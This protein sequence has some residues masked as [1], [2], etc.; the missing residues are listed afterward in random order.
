MGSIDRRLPIYLWLQAAQYQIILLLRF[1]PL[2]YS[3]QEQSR[4]LEVFSTV[5]LYW[6]RIIPSPPPLETLFSSVQSITGFVNTEQEKAA[7]NPSF[8]NFVIVWRAT[9][10]HPRRSLG[11]ERSTYVHHASAA[12][13]P[14]S[15]P[16]GK[17]FHLIVFDYLFIFLFV[18]QI[19]TGGNPNEN[20][21]PVLYL[22]THTQ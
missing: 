13:N 1:L 12:H 7:A 9:I 2:G 17:W 6:G 11:R 18:K 19:Q 5:R 20:R 21:G 10:R 15:P 3:T 8:E 22:Y 14:T 4:C 16:Q